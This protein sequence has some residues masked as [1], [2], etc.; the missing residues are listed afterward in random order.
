MT[1]TAWSVSN[2]TSASHFLVMLTCGVLRSRR[3]GS[4]RG[5]KVRAGVIAL[6][7]GRMREKLPVKKQ[8]HQQVKPAKKYDDAGIIPMT[9]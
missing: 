3:G 4:V 1:V 6:T 7:G 5:A 9:R 8:I 2:P